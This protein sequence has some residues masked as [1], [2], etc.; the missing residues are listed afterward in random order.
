M[1]EGTGTVDKLELQVDLKRFR[2]RLASDHSKGNCLPTTLYRK[3]RAALYES[4]EFLNKRDSGRHVEAG[5]SQGS[6]NGGG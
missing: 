5:T 6:K 1:V 3:L 2:D 4:T